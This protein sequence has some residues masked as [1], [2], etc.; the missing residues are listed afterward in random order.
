MELRLA[1]IDEMLALRQHFRSS[2]QLQLWGGEGFEFPLTSSRFLQQLQKTDLESFVLVHQQHIVAFGQIC[3]RFGKHHLARLLVLP[4][5]R[6]RGYG[7]LLLQMLIERAQ[8]INKR[9]D[10]SLFVYTSNHNAISL[11]QK[12]GF[13]V[14]TQP[15]Q[16]RDDLYFMTLT[17]S[18]A[19]A[20]NQAP[21]S[22][23]PLNQASFSQ[24]A[25]S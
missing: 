14:T 7:T 6:R 21:L 9:L 18:Q 13:Q 5:Y 16:H 19:T 2:A 25:E 3:D 11:Y 1:T 10:F 17:A 24:P 22:Q 8:R 4:A 23:A 12:L 20:L 15:Q